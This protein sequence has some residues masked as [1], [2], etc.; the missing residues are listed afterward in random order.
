[1]GAGIIFNMEVL[2]MRNKIAIITIVCAIFF[3]CNSNNNRPVDH[4]LTLSPEEWLQQYNQVWAVCYKQIPEVDVNT[5]NAEE[6]IAN[7]TEHMQKV[8]N[9]VKQEF[10]ELYAYTKMPEYQAKLIEQGQNVYNSIIQQT[11]RELDQMDVELNQ[12]VERN[13]RELELQK[14][15]TEIFLKNYHAPEY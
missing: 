11:Q 12:Q 13:Q 10:P 6:F 3:S 9:L 5:S 2:I 14:Q 4:L 1:M 8:E 7:S 15:K